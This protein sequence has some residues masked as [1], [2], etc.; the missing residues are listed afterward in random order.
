M[1]KKQNRGNRLERKNGTNLDQLLRFGFRYQ[2]KIKK[3]QKN[4]GQK[5]SCSVFL[6]TPLEEGEGRA[7][8]VRGRPLY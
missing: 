5:S 8:K 1:G 2:E 7:E 6:V 3:M 4:A